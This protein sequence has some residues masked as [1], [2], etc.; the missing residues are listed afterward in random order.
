MEQS[1]EIKDL[2]HL[3]SQGDM[4]AYQ[5]LYGYFFP[6]LYKFANT[7]LHAPELAEE[8]V[9]DVFIKIWQKRT[10]LSRIGN[11]TLYLYISTKNRSID[12]ARNRSRRQMVFVNESLQ[13]NSVS[14]DQHA[15][16]LLF[17]NELLLQVREAIQKLPPQ[18]GLVFKLVKEDGL[19]YRE[20]ARLLGLSQK[21]VENHMTLAL[22]KFAEAMEPNF[23]ELMKSFRKKN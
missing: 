17:R 6:R 3:V 11:I 13:S 16:Q 12:Y 21:T 22:R 2:A 10:A 23:P 4:A 9:S 5:R 19:K 18:A 7:Y 20:V 1:P 14:G 15:D 8:V